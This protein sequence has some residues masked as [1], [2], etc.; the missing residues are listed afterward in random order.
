M[1]RWCIAA[2][3]V[4]G[5]TAAAGGASAQV[6]YPQIVR[7]RYEASDA[8]GGSFIIWLDRERIHHGL[9]SRLYP[10]AQYVEVTHLTPSPGSPTISMIEIMNVNASVPEFYHIAGIARFKISGMVVKSTNAPNR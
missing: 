5:F 10:A 7:I 9:D 3:L 1:R 8:K 4:L 2:L 6:A